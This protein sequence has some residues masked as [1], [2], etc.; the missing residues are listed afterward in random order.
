MR[1]RQR[2]CRCAVQQLELS[3]IQKSHAVLI[4]TPLRGYTSSVSLRSTASP[5]GE[6]KYVYRNRLFVHKTIVCIASR[7]T[8]DRWSPLQ[9]WYPFHLFIGQDVWDG[10]VYTLLYNIIINFLTNE[11]L[12]GIIHLL[13]AVTET[14]DWQGIL[15]R[16]GDGVSPTVAAFS[17]ITPELQ[18]EFSSPCRC[19]SVTLGAYDC[20]QVVSKVPFVLRRGIFLLL[21]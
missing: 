12:G 4:G 2:S 15:K 9:Q 6:T 16:V 3:L 11:N 19:P 7:K 14:V 1:C 13:K 17:N 20:M 5:Q 10:G 18:G 8:D 21:F